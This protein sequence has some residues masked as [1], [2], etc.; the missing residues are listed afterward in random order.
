MA[1]CRQCNLLISGAA[2]RCPRCGYLLPSR[3]RIATGGIIIVGVLI[4]VFAALR[5]GGSLVKEQGAAAPSSKVG[6]AAQPVPTAVSPVLISDLSVAQNDQPSGSDKP[7]FDCAKAKTAAARLI[8]ADVELARLDSELGAAY[9]RRKAQIAPPDQVKFIAEQ[10]AWIRDRNTRC[11]LDG[12]DSATIEVLASSKACVASLI[13]ERIALL[14]KAAATSS[15]EVP[16]RESTSLVP[17]TSTKIPTPSG[18][19]LATE[20]DANDCKSP[21]I[22]RELRGCTHLIQDTRRAQGDRAM[23]FYNRGIANFKVKII[24]GPSRITRRLFDSIQPTLVHLTIGGTLMPRFKIRT[25]LS[26]TTRPLFD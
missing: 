24:T 14:V 7:S 4:V 12:K 20:E 22:A 18:T 17:T 23:A 11:E 16:T 2:E 8:C 3:F 13:R 9:Q 25:E 26:Q 6:E 19:S 5:S 10:R 15:R 21:D 1:R